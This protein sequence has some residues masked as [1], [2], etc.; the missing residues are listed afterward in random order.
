VLISCIKVKGFAF[1]VLHLHVCMQEGIV[2][3]SLPKDKHTGKVFEMYTK[4]MGES[5]LQLVDVSSGFA[6]LFS[7]KEGPELMNHKKV[8]AF[9]KL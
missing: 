6:E 4:V 8:G 2:V 7:I 9:V 1:H 5:G 3:G